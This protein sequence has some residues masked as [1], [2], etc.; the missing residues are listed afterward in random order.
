MHLNTPGPVAQSPVSG[1]PDMGSLLNQGAYSFGAPGGGG[2]PGSGMGGAPGGGQPPAGGVPQGGGPG[3]ID[4]AALRQRLDQD[5]A[6]QQ[7]QAGIWGQYQP[8]G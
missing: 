1:L 4:W 8:T 3:G 6:L 7:V 5:T 2:M